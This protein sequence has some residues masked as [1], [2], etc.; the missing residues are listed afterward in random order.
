MRDESGFTIIEAL[1]AMAILSIALVALYGVGSDLL[2]ASTHVAGIDRAALFVQ[3]K[4]ETL[5]SISTPLPA[6]S[7]GHDEGFGWQV[8]VQNLPASS[9]TSKLVLQELQLV[10]SWRD[11]INERS[12]TVITRHLGRTGP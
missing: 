4:L 11:G 6:K 2:R 12:L 3:S 1:V 10:V 7:E 8:T 5:S 9:P